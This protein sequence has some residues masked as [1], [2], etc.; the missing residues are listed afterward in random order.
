MKK[1][2]SPPQC[3]RVSLKAGAL[4]KRGI[5][6]DSVEVRINEQGLAHRLCQLARVDTSGEYVDALA[7]LSADVDQF[8]PHA[9]AFE[10]RPETHGTGGCNVVGGGRQIVQRLL[11]HF[12]CY[13][14]GHATGFRPSL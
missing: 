1:K 7:S 2:A 12:I 9:L 6:L 5:D 4:K 10:L 3:S 14:T 13:Q 11:H 8:G